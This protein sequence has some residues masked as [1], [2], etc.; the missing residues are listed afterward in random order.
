MQT[1]TTAAT[2]PK[3]AATLPR[4][5]GPLGR[6]LKKQQEAKE[7]AA[8]AQKLATISSMRNNVLGLVEDPHLFSD[9]ERAR[10]AASVAGC[11]CV[12]RLQR[13]FRNVYRIAKHREDC[14]QLAFAD[15]STTF[16]PVNA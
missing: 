3:V 10:T 12:A 16:F 15:G 6:F 9:A 4:Y 8:E 5:K 13:W 7:A 11:G 14:L 2:S 1:A